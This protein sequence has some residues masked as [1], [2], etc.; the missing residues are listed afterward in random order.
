MDI[1]QFV[2]DKFT[3]IYDIKDMVILVDGNVIRDIISIDVMFDSD[4]VN[5]VKGFNGETNYNI[6]QNKSGKISIKV[7]DGTFENTT[8]F[9]LT[10]MRKLPGSI[11]KFTASIMDINPLALNFIFSGCVVTNLPSVGK[12]KDIGE[13]QYTINFS[14]CS[15]FYR[16]QGVFGL[17]GDIL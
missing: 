10:Q 13:L 3:N 11:K 16:G 4:I 9:D 6:S 14:N 5:P 17:V 1:M 7:L 2:R 8:L 15:G 12:T